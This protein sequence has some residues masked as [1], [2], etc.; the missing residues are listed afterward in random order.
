VPAWYI[1]AVSRLDWLKVLAAVLV[2]LNVPLLL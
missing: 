2:E 1:V